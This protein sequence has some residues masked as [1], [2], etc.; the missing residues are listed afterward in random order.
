[1]TILLW[2]FA[3]VIFEALLG[4]AVGKYLKGRG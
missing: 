1:M 3:F 2:I 4:M